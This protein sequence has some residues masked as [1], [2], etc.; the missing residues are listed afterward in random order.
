LLLPMTTGWASASTLPALVE[1]PPTP[2]TFP[3]LVEL[4]ALPP[5]KC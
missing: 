5:L 3:P 4:T 2:S 1:L